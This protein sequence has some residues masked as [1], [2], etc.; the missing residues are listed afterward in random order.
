VEKNL[1]EC[2]IYLSS[3]EV[4]SVNAPGITKPEEGFQLHLNNFRYKLMLFENKKTLCKEIRQR[5]RQDCGSR[6]FYS[7]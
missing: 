6:T 3:M 4:L 5:K 2:K 1:S 7:G